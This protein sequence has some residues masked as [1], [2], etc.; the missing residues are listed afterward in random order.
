MLLGS[1]FIRICNSNSFSYVIHVI[2]VYF[3]AVSRFRGIFFFGF[4]VLRN[5]FSSFAVLRKFFAVLRFQ[6]PL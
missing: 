6:L 3:S 1:R 4:A 2:N 5:I